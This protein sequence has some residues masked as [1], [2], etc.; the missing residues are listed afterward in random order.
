MSPP[1]F[2][3]DEDGGHLERQA[4]A[5]LQV[6]GV[7]GVFS[8]LDGDIASELEAQAER[9]ALT[10]RSRA[11]ATSRIALGRRSPKAIGPGPS[12]GVGGAVEPS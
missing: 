2:P 1:G 9:R 6:A 7:E 11:L 5:E 4:T 10:S 8:S 3:V 12:P